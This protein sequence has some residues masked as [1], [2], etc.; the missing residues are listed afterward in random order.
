MVDR[1][2]RVPLAEIT[3]AKRLHQLYANTIWRRLKDKG[4]C[5]R[6]EYTGSSYDGVKVRRSDDDSDLEFDIMV[7]LRRESHLRVVYLLL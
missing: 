4:I 5:S 1:F 3:D 6:F 2:A 7:I